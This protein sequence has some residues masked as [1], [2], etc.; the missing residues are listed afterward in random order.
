MGSPVSKRP[1]L[2]P[3][4]PLTDPA[5]NGLVFVIYIYNYGIYIYALH[6]QWR[7]SW[8]DSGRFRVHLC[9]MI[10]SRVKAT[11]FPTARE[12]GQL[13]YNHGPDTHTRMHAHTHTHTHTFCQPTPVSAESRQGCSVVCRITGAGA[14]GVKWDDSGLWE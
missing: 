6:L 10:A 1:L 7:D 9:R 5:C 13:S 4:P 3:H 8:M 2:L 12:T 14:D 11:L